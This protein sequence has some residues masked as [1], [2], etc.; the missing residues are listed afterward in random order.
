MAFLDFLVIV[1]M[2][3][4]KIPLKSTWFWSTTMFGFNTVAKAHLETVASNDWAQVEKDCISSIPNC[5]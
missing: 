2:G 3:G 5:N 4:T 1:F